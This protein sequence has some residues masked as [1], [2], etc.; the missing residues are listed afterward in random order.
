[1]FI[2][3]DVL[4]Y[5]NR[6]SA[7]QPPPP[8]RVSTGMPCTLHVTM[9]GK[10]T[11][12]EASLYKASSISDYTVVPRTKSIFELHRKPFASHLKSHIIAGSWRVYWRV[13]DDPVGDGA[14]GTMRWSCFIWLMCSYCSLASQSLNPYGVSRSTSGFTNDVSVRNTTVQFRYTAWVLTMRVT[15]AGRHWL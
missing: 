8:A 14:I 6:F 3:T 9:V 11:P 10:L 4:T 2:R 13:V 1:V 5:L 7:T 12:E 15:H